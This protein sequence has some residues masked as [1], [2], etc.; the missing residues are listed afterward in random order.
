MPG[1]PPH[2]Y[3]D[4]AN[5]NHAKRVS[6]DA[7]ASCRGTHDTVRP[8]KTP[9]WSAGG[10][11]KRKSPVRAF[12]PAHRDESTSPAPI[13]KPTMKTLSGKGRGSIYVPGKPKLAMHDEE[14]EEDEEYEAY[15]PHSRPKPILV[16]RPSAIVNHARTVNFHR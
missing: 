4:I 8:S 7:A 10:V 3:A 15:M 11:R 14:Y 2:A 12:S 9:P 5:S 1:T 16:P 13:V 6:F